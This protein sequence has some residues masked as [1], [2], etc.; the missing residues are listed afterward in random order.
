MNREEYIYPNI[1]VGINE[2]GITLVTNVRVLSSDHEY[3]LKKVVQSY[4]I[5]VTD[6][7]KVT[8]AMSKFYITCYLVMTRQKPHWDDTRDTVQT[9]EYFDIFKR[10][11]IEQ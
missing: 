3:M 8:G 9:D 6:P 5:D 10:L 1:Q 7:I 4:H 2:K 11:G